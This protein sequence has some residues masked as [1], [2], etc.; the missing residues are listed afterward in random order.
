MSE[1]KYYGKAADGM[2]EDL[3]RGIVQIG[4]SEAHLKTLYEKAVG[5]LEEGIIDVENPDVV[6]NQL[7]KIDDIVEEINSNASLR[8]KL[9][10]SLFGMYEG[11]K[12][13]WC[14]VKHLG[15]ASYC[16]FEAYQASDNDTELLNLALE[17]NK[18]FTRALSHFLGT[19]ITE[20][21]AC[22]S[23]FLKGTADLKGE[24]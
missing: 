8:R 10:A 17:T 22:F 5:E 15:I 18:A 12:T 21:A 16:V 3:I 19:E 9:M 1:N 20:C 24:E 7:Q 13:Y 6:K 14:E 4:C 11:D 23:D 2:A